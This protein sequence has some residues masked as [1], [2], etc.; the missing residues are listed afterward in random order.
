MLWPDPITPASKPAFVSIT[1]CRCD[2]MQGVSM[3]SKCLQKHTQ[4]METQLHKGAY[5]RAF[6]RAH[7]LMRLRSVTRN[8]SWRRS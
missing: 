1:I 6:E 8:Y 7:E 2:Q 3:V 4:H 5:T